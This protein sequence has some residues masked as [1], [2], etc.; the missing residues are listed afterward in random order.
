MFSI[1]SLIGMDSAVS[2]SVQDITSCDPY[3]HDC[4][5]ADKSYNECTE[6]QPTLALPTY[7][8]EECVLNCDV[9]TLQS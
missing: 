9:S 3:N 7:N 6:P 8:L 4:S 1:Q 2:I 5:C